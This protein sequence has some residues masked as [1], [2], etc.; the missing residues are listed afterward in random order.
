M[1]RNFFS[2]KL[3]HRFFS[4]IIR[5]HPVKS[6]AEQLEEKK[7]N[8]VFLKHLSAMQKKIAEIK[9]NPDRYP[10]IEVSNSNISPEEAEAE[11]RRNRM[12]S[13]YG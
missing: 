11:E 10:K 3:S 12:H 5:N 4:Q 7:K 9:S 2:T 8:P 13:V 6:V 1:F